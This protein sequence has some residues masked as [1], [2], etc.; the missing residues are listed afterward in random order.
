MVATYSLISFTNAPSSNAANTLCLAGDLRSQPECSAIGEML[1]GK[2]VVAGHRRN[3]A[4]RTGA[5]LVIPFVLLYYFVVVVRRRR[6]RLFLAIVVVV[7]VR[8]FYHFNSFFFIIII[9]IDN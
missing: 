8:S 5:R 7:Y 3:H 4:R 1:V 2:S 6:R 9:I